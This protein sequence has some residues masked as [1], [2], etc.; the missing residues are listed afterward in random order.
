MRFLIISSLVFLAACSDSSDSLDHAE[1]TTKTQE[2][3]SPHAIDDLKEQ[4]GI[5]EPFIESDALAKSAEENKP[6][7]LYFTGWSVTGSRMLEER[8]FFTE[9][10]I[11]HSLLND[12]IFVPLYVDDRIHLPEELHSVEEISGRKKSVRTIGDLNMVYQMR[13]TNSIAQPLIL[14]LNSEGDIL[15]KAGY[16]DLVDSDFNALLEDALEEFRD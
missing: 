14:I 13:K 4:M 1:D 16:R 6:L 5:S 15:K 9:P 10:R 3:I 7:F 8:L 12:F 2:R 11:A